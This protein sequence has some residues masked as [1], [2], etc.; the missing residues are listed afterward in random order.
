MKGLFCD[1]PFNSCHG[2]VLSMISE[3]GDGRSCFLIENE[4][5]SQ[6]IILDLS[7]RSSFTDYL[8]FFD[9]HSV[10]LVASPRRILIATGYFQV[11]VS[12]YCKEKHDLQFCACMF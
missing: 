1:V 11:Q 10:G 5:E 7:I 2:D 3:Y 4:C 12:I 8:A 6:F 9:L